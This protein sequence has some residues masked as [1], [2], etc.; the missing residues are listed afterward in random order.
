MT[1]DQLV[2]WFKG[3]P[4]DFTPGEKFSY[5]NSGYDLLGYIIEKASGQTY[6]TFLKENIFD[7][8]G[9]SNSGYNPNP[10]Y[11]AIGYKE[12]SYGYKADPLDLSIA[13]ACGGIYSTIED[14]YKWDQA[15]YTE[16]LLPQKLLDEMFKVQVVLDPQYPSI[17]YGYGW[18]VS[19]MNGHRLVS[20]IGNAAGFITEILRF[21]DDK[22]TVIILSNNETLDIGVVRDYIVTRLLP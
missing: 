20:H 4:L 15:L 1:P 13:Y 18:V 6:G 7:P 2:E 22:V 5:T 17:G 8:L 11:L 3:K 9:M 16:K 21:P 12:Y 10:E 14:L 19:D